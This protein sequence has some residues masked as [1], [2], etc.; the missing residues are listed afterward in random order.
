MYILTIDVSFLN[1]SGCLVFTVLLTFFRLAPKHVLVNR[2][3]GAST[4]IHDN[5]SGAMLAIN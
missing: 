5:R 3:H 1:K 2:Q 4:V